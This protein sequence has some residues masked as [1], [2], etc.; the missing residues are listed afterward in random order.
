MS[1]LVL[2]FMEGRLAP[3]EVVVGA[4]AGVAVFAVGVHVGAVASTGAAESACVC[5]GGDRC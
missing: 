4:W 2:R 5:A 3:A 1:H